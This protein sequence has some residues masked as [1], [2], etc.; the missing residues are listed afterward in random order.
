MV[1]DLENPVHRV[2]LNI[3]DWSDLPVLSDDVIEYTLT[4]NAGNE[5]AASKICATY[6]LGILS[7]QTHERLDRIELWGS[8]RFNNYMKYIKEFITSPIGGLFANAGIY[9]AGIDRA[10]VE[11]NNNDCTIIQNKIPSYNSSG[12]GELDNP[13]STF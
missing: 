13:Y 3:A 5:A 8:E 11:A 1:L 7:Q 6:V 2:R 12:A 10:E 4:Q 9:A